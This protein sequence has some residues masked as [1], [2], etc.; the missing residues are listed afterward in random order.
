MDKAPVISLLA[1]SSFETILTFLALN[2]LGYAVLF[3]STRL[4]ASAYARLMEMADSHRLI[5]HENF[6][7]VAADVQLEQPDCSSISLIE[8]T[9]WHARPVVKPISRPDASAVEEGGKIAWILHSS[10]STGFPKPI[11]LTNRQCLANFK[12][13]FNLRSFCTSPLFHSHALM[14]FGRALYTKA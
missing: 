13:S 9:G 12:K 4:T 14:E 7:S 10:G 8:R 2:R 3:L 5:I 1:G 6:Q 11:F